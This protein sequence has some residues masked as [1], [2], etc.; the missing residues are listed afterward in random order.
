MLLLEQPRQA[1]AVA[2]RGERSA[3][4]DVQVGKRVER[5]AG[6]ERRAAMEIGS[7]S[8]T[9][10]TMSRWL[11]TRTSGARPSIC[12][13]VRVRDADVGVGAVEHHPHAVAR[14]AHQVERL[15]TELGVLQ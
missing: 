15:E 4:V 11:G 7:P 1:A 2:L 8:L 3:V 13:D 10:R 9:E 6:S 5:L 14:V 12:D